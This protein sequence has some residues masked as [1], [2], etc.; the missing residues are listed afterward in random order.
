MNNYRNCRRCQRKDPPQCWSPDRQECVDCAPE[1][2]LASCAARERY[3]CPNPN[4]EMHAD[5]PPVNPLYTGC[6]MCRK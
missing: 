5:V 3:G 6:R 1:K 2:A 4:G